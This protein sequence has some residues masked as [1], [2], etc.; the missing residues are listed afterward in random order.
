MSPEVSSFWTSSVGPDSAVCDNTLSSSSLGAT[1]CSGS[2]MV[3]RLDLKEIGVGIVDISE[4]TSSAAQSYYVVVPESIT[5]PG[6]AC[7]CVVDKATMGARG[8][9]LVNTQILHPW[10]YSTACEIVS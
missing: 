10:L 5:E 8:C 9:S 7:Y 1:G 4:L 2:D 6:N 3:A